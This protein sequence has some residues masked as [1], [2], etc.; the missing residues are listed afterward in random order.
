MDPRI[1]ISTLGVADFA[2]SFDFYHNKPGFPTNRRP[3]EGVI[4]FQTE[5]L[6]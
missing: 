2:R 6:L 1:S 3:E 4:F 5:G